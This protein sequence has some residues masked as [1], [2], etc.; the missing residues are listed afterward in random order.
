VT[1]KRDLKGYVQSDIIQLTSLTFFPE[2]YAEE[3]QGNDSS[4]KTGFIVHNA[5]KK[6][7]LL[8]TSKKDYSSLMPRTT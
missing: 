7:S 6:N 5:D 8:T 4:L 1:Q 2:Q 3:V